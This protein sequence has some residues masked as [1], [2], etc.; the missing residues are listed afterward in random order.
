[1]GIF[2]PSGDAER[3]SIKIEELC[4]TVTKD[5]THYISDTHA[6]PVIA[7]ALL[8]GKGGSITCNPGLLQDVV[9]LGYNTLITSGRIKSISHMDSLEGITISSVESQPPI[10]HS[11]PIATDGETTVN[12]KLKCNDNQT[13]EEASLSN[14]ALVA[15]AD[16]HLDGT[17]LSSIPNQGSIVSSGI[18]V[19]APILTN[20]GN[21]SN[22]KECVIS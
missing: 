11:K 10:A 15:L 18:T 5:S 9:K 7:A 4:S 1:M 8:A 14:Q 19:S 22:G 12:Q 20:A 13:I 16:E 2:S 6:A 17:R 3:W 21:T